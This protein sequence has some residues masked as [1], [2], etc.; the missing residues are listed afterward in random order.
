MFDELLTGNGGEDGSD[1]EKIEA[2]LSALKKGAEKILADPAEQ[3]RIGIQKLNAESQKFF[4]QSIL[5]VYRYHF[6]IS[7]P[8]Y[9]EMILEFDLSLN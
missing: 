7:F 2:M 6:A 8:V 1:W 9:R 3:V 5:E 4:M